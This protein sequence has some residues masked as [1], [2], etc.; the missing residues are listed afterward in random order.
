MKTEIELTEQE[1][2][3]LREVRNYFGSHDATMF[4][5]KA[6]SIMNNLIKK[7]H[8]F[9]M[10]DFEEVCEIFKNNPTKRIDYIQTHTADT[11]KW[12]IDK[13]ILNLTNEEVDAADKSTTGYLGIHNGISC[14]VQKR[15]VEHSV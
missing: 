13:E 2:K 9:T 14:Y 6:Y 15:V 5:H 11:W 1:I 12:L 10:E 4:E 7:L 3:D 8:V